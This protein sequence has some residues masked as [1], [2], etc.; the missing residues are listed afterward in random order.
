MLTPDLCQAQWHE[1]TRVGGLGAAE[2]LDPREGAEDFTG[3]AFAH[4][5]EVQVGQRRLER[6][7]TEVVADEPDRAE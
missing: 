3:L 4:F 7:V 6:G 5:G 1:R 2:V